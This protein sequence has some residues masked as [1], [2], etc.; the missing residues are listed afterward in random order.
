MK[1]YN[2][3]ALVTISISTTVEANSLWEAIEIAEDRGIRRVH[4][5]DITQDKEVW[6][7][8]EELDGEPFNIV[9]E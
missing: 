5:G 2:L 9:E 8:S 7:Y 6:I 3:G 4:W 1:E